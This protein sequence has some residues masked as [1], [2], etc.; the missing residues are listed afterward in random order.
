MKIAY[1]S[2]NESIHDYRFL[3]KLV[4]KGYETHLINFSDPDKMLK[5]EG[6][7]VHNLPL[8]FSGFFCWEPEVLEVLSILSGFIVF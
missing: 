1:I 7:I 8:Q 4:E 6:L 3:T 5:I 2:G